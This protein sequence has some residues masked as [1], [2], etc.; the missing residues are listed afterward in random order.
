LMVTLQGDFHSLRIT[1]P[2]FGTAFNVRKE[3]GGQVYFG[4]LCFRLTNFCETP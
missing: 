2:Q 4:R 1:F 3:E